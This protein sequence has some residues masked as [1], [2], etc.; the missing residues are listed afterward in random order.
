MSSITLQW[1]L[2]RY[3]HVV[4]NKIKIKTN[5]IGRLSR[6]C[7]VTFVTENLWSLKKKQAIMG[8]LEGA[9]SAQY[10][11]HLNTVLGGL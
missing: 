5:R 10:F 4:L 6:N 9:D 7:H 2:L 1:L 8:P 3:Y 11:T